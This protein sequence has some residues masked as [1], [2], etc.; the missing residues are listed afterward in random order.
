MKLIN[1]EMNKTKFLDNQ[2]SLSAL[3]QSSKKGTHDKH[4]IF[5]EFEKRNTLMLNNIVK[6]ISKSQNSQPSTKAQNLN[7]I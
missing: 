3:L 2:K 5:E 6:Q 1:I 7:I 4:Q